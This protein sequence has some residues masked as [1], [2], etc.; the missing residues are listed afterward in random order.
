M[1]TWVLVYDVVKDRRRAR[2]FRKLK[3][4]MSPVQLS[5]FEGRLSPAA[6]DEVETLV[7]RELD[8]RTDSVRLYPLCA[9]CRALAR[10][11]GVAPPPHDPDEP[12][13]L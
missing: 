7:R 10:H 13:I 9:R 1:S 2:F 6:L 3:R 5:V 8:L 11:M 4:L 12:T